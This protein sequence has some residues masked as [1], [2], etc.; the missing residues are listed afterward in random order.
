MIP[1]EGTVRKEAQRKKRSVLFQR[2]E[3]KFGAAS[4][5]I[6]KCNLVRFRRALGSPRRFQNRRVRWVDLGFRRIPMRVVAE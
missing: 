4:P 5:Q 6:S 1:V 3:R 2:Q